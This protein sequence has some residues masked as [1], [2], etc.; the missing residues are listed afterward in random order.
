LQQIRPKLV[1]DLGANTGEYSR[2]ARSTGATVVAIDGDPSAVERAYRRFSADSETGILP[3]W[4]DLANP[5]PAQGWA[6]SEWPSLEARGP[7]DLVL[8]LALVH[9]LAVGNNVPLP[10]VAAFLSRLGRRVIV[11][12]VPKND[13]QVQRLLRSRE[14]VFTGYNEESFAAAVGQVFNIDERRPVGS[15]GRILYLLSAVNSR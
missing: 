1:F 3:L 7:A 14:D 8:A 4:I 11:E 15:T 10:H 6:H 5:T 12:W 9:H 13:P 2:L